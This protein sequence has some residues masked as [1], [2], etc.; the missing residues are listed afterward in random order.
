MTE[1]EYLAYDGSHDGKHEYVSGEVIAM[2]GVSDA[3][4]RVQVNAV[5]ALANRLRGGPCRVRGSDFASG[6][7]R[8]AS[9]VTRTSRSCA[10]TPYSRPR[11]Q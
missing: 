2:S 3:H 5:V 10:V 4:D 7:T 6:S 8:R 1:A 11:I 9:I